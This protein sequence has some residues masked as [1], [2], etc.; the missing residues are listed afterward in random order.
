MRKTVAAL[1]MLG[2]ILSI[3]TVHGEVCN[4]MDNC[5]S[6]APLGLRAAARD[7]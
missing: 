3:S 2:M 5:Q 6:S 7:R 4:I 1:T